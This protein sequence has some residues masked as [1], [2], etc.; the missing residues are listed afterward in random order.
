LGNNFVIRARKRR[1]TATEEHERKVAVIP[2]EEPRLAATEQKK[3][4]S[5]TAR[6]CR[7]REGFGA[8]CPF[9][10]L[11]PEDSDPELVT[12]VRSA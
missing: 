3:L 4:T 9:L 5:R 6:S 12:R 1:S 10:S 2:S 8:E 11:V 7:G